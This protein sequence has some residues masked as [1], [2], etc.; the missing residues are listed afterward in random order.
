M[1][2]KESEVQEKYLSNRVQWRGFVGPGRGGNTPPI[3]EAPRGTLDPWTL[4]VVVVVV[5]DNER[6]DREI[7][8]VPGVGGE[9]WKYLRESL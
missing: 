5:E 8:R 2:Q 9:D 4:V 7:H 3:L 1:V 6:R